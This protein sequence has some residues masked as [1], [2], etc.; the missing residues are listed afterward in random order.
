LSDT[1]RDG[2]VRRPRR[3]RG[4]RGGIGIDTTRPRADTG[5]RQE[6]DVERAVPD[7]V[8]WLKRRD[9]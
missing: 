1:V 3:C 4:G 5:F 7:Y 2:L 8:D 6:Y 9:R